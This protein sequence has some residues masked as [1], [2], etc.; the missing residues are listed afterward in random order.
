[1]EQLFIAVFV[2]FKSQYGKER[3]TVKRLIMDP[4]TQKNIVNQKHKS[5][6]TGLNGG[7]IC[8]S[9]NMVWRKFIMFG[10]F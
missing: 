9:N 7:A 8:T 2:K 5:Y 10:L 4:V 1:M 6:K 3:L